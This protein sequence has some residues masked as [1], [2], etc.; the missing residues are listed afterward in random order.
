MLKNM[1]LLIIED[2]ILASN[3][4]KKLVGEIDPSIEV[5]DVIDSV[6]DGIRWFKTYDAPD[7]ILT[8]IQLADGL[9]FEIFEQCTPTAPLIFTTAYDNFAIKAFKVNG[10]DYLL[11]PIDKE[12]LSTALK[13]AANHFQN[14]SLD[15]IA[16]ASMLQ[17][18]EEKQYKERFIVKIGEQLKFIKTEEIAYF[19]SEDGYAHLVNWSGEKQIIDFSLDQLKE[20]LNPKQFQRINR[21]QVVNIDSIDRVST[22]FNSRLKLKLK[23]DGL[24]AIVSRDRAGAFKAWLDQ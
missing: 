14:K 4:L 23:P 6:E 13:K 2:E 10:I 21:Q 9:S 17:K 22:Y 24:E 18:G 5:I 15:L 20:M 7:I 8:D 11:K 12:G 16:L 1:R 19:I 3:R